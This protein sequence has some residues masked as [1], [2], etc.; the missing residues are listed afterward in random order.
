MMGESFEV[1][2]ERHGDNY[3]KTIE[4]AVQLAKMLLEPGQRFWVC[5]EN[6]GVIHIG[7][8]PRIV[9]RS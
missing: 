1:A 6:G 9:G 2:K 4:E 7:Q 5:D 8:A 3:F